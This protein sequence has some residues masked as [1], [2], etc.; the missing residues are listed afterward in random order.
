VNTF[1]EICAV[2]A[3]GVMVLILVVMLICY[4]YIMFKCIIEDK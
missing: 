3:L 4:V 1:A 2:I